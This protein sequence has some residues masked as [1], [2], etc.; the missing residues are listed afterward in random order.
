MPTPCI[1]NPYTVLA[2]YALGGPAIGV[3]QEEAKE[4]E[5][6]ALSLRNEDPPLLEKFLA[7]YPPRDPRTIVERAEEAEGLLQC[8]WR[9]D[10]EGVFHPQKRGLYTHFK[11]GTY[12]CH[13]EAKLL[14]GPKE[15]IAVVY[16][17]SGE[18]LYVRPLREWVAIVKWPDGKYRPRFVKE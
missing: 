8:I 16:S 3:S 4:A 11:G 6:F 14:Q 1:S 5:K 9:G 2:G 18:D 13:G 15:E 10:Y 17:S 12:L 7:L